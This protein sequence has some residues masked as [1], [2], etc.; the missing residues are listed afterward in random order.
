MYQMCLHRSWNSLG[1]HPLQQQGT[2]GAAAGT[3][4]CKEWRGQPKAETKGV[5]LRTPGTGGKCALCLG[6]PGWVFIQVL[7]NNAAAGK[8]TSPLP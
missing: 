7:Q 4:D 2:R 8:T 3:A 5:S 1:S 6:A